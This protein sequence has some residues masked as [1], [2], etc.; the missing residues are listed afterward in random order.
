MAKRAS[1]FEWSSPK[2]TKIDHS[3]RQQ[4]YKELVEQKARVSQHFNTESVP[5]EEA[6]R[7]LEGLRDGCLGQRD[8]AYHGNVIEQIVVFKTR[9]L[10]QQAARDTRLFAYNTKLVQLD[11]GRYSEDRTAGIWTTEC[12]AAFEARK[13]P[14]V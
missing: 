9:L 14:I 10:Q 6:I 3:W 13:M 7:H 1:E 5:T 2:R 11:F 4:Q 12:W 8:C